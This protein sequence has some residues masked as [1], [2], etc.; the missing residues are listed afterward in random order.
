MYAAVS[1]AGLA[2]RNKVSGLI[3]AALIACV[4]IGGG[5]YIIYYGN[6]APPP[7]ALPAGPPHATVLSQST[8]T[9]MIDGNF[10]LTEAMYRTNDTPV[11]VIAFYHGLLKGY[12]NQ[13]GSFLQHSETIDPTNAPEAL[14][15][16]PPAFADGEA[17]NYFYTQYSFGQSDVGVA[18]D[19]RHPKG[20]T[21]VY[22]EMLTLPD[23]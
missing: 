9:D 12:Q 15:H 11:K 19:A 21:Y 14:Q 10:V 17:A 1:T 8:T 16:M 5:V 4:V 2:R 3:I 18:V 13:I 23:S 20:P 6:N 22:L 7:P